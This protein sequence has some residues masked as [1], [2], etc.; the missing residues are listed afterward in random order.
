MHSSRMRT[1]R[2]SSRL[3]GGM[4]TS[5]HA[6]IPPCGCVP[7]DPLGCGSGDPSRSDPSTSPPLGVD[8]ETPPGQTAQLS[9][10]VW[11]WRPPRPDSSTSPLGVGLET[12]PRPDPS[13]SPLNVG[14]KTCN[15]TSFAGGKT[16]IVENKCQQWPETGGCTVVPAKALRQVTVDECSKCSN[17]WQFFY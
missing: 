14:L 7:G 13:T 17:L 16:Y 10:W 9:P 8:L 15:A 11:A 12:L 4:S 2:S 1:A 5:V 6:G 3:L